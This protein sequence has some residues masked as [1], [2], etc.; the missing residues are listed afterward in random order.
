MTKVEEKISVL[1][2]TYN[3]Q[4]KIRSSLESILDQTYEN[5]EFIILDDNSEDGTFEILEEYESKND[6]IKLLK[7]ESNMGL[8]KSLNI[9]ISESSGN[10]IA[11]QDDDDFSARN[12]LEIQMRLM[13][14]FE[15]DFC[16]LRA[17]T[18][19]E[20][21]L[22][23]GLSYYLPNKLLIKYKNPFIHGSL[24]IKKSVLEKNGN[25]DEDFYYAQDYKLM[26][27]LLKKGYKYRIINNPLYK[28]NTK[29]NISELK[30]TEQKYYADCVKKNIRPEIINENLH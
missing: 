13:K 16:T 21:K 25:Y 23:P 15:L 17:I 8:T 6:S 28:L 2:S 1:M 10:Y 26:S 5:L 18:M 11:R 29:N 20:E 3:S 19:P 24:L 27:D 7:N 22:R 30:K 4:D 14:K 12:R 9:L